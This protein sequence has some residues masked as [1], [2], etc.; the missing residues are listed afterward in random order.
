MKEDSEKS[1]TAL[2]VVRLI[3]LMD[4]FSNHKKTTS[5]KL[6][7]EFD[8]TPRTIFRDLDLLENELN[9][10][11]ISVEGSHIEVMP[12]WKFR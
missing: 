1:R 11:F 8:V 12:D 10:P 9:V 5:S 6:A 3:K 7:E 2:R 4:Y